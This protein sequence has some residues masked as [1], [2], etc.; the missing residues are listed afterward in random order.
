MTKIVPLKGVR[1]MIA[2]AMVKSLASGAQLTHHKSADATALIAIKAR[3]GKLG[4]KV[5]VED[6]LMLSVVQALK[7]HPEA[8]GRVEGREVHLSDAVDLS[9]AIA[10]PGNLLVA[11]AIFGA[12]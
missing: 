12:E 4:S 6:L 10:L 3:L 5:S 11:P 2:D 9:V 7:T 8:N 1:R